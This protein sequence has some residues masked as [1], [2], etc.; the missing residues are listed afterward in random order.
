MMV[1]F[2]PPE[3]AAFVLRRLTENG[4]TAVFVGGCVRD[5]VM[6]RPVHDW[7]VATSA[8]PDEVA[9]I[10]PKTV[11]TGEKFGTVT[12]CAGEGTIEVTTF[13]VESEYN[14]NRRPDNVK[15]VV[16]LD[17]DLSRR[18]FTINAMAIPV[19][20][21]L[22]DPFGGIEDIKNRIIRCVGDPG[23]RFSE[24][25]LRMFRAFRFRAELGFAIEEETF[26]AIYANASR[27]KLIS[28][29][30]IRVELEKTLMSQK[31]EIAGEMMQAGLL[32][33]YM[34]APGKKLDGLEK[35]KWIPQ[36]AAMHWCAFCA[37]LLEESLIV[38][39]ADFLKNMRMDGKTTRIC[40]RAL[41]MIR[42]D[43]SKQG[44]AKQGGAKQ[45]GAKQGDGSSAWHCQA[46]EP[47]PCLVSPRI[48][49]RL[50]SEHG[51]D[52]VRCAAAVYDMVEQVEQGGGTK[53]GDGSS[54]WFHKADEPS[55]C[56]FAPCFM[57]LA[58]TD[59]IIASGECYSLGKLAV[60]GSDLLGLG[61][62]PGQ[63]L[64]EMLE[65][66]LNYVIINPEANT[67]GKLLNMAKK[68]E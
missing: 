14:D 42:G 34:T 11:L 36:E 61:Y 15:F 65:K 24:D 13:R 62:T 56:F 28:A 10:F 44:G 25:A 7:D 30:R 18:D 51:E 60:T 68:H 66:L 3:H 49:K 26:H 58:K 47:S 1:N 67:R 46:D 38:S 8:T 20:G 9:L 35:I 22:I 32:D 52:A 31:P 45:G 16:N 39:A 12:V 17:D 63:E 21:S 64:G 6:G 59:E 41:S 48:I 4:Y 55:P 43:G 53:Q 23:A 5:A 27:A 19:S 29:E 37:V 54:A 40:I 33:C 2:N 50:L 57:S